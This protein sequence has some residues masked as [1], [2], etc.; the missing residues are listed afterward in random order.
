VTLVSLGLPVYNGER[1]LETALKALL[2][3][4][5]EDIELV[6]SDN[7][8]TDGTEEL[9]RSFAS[10]DSRIVYYRQE[11]N[12]GAAWNHNFVV[13]ASHGEYFRWCSYDDIVAPELVADCLEV[14]ESDPRAVLSFPGTYVIDG[15]G[16]IAGEY[17]MDLPWVGES[18]QSRLSNLLLPDLPDSLINYCYP[19]YGVIRR[20]VLLQ[21]P[22]LGTYQS[23]DNILLVE[24]ALRGGWIQVPRRLF[25]SRRHEQSSIGTRTKRE[26]AR[27]FNPGA[28]LRTTPMVHTNLLMGYRQ[29]LHR[30]P[31]GKRERLACYGIVVRWVFRDRN[32]R[33]IFHEFRQPLRERLTRPK[34]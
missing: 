11:V 22:L 12:R 33:M 6:I 10:A 17:T 8:S 30:V 26:I 25:Y 7:A 32:G 2:A 27:W 3:Q 16:E 13:R 15:A 19:I 4:S 24:L 21:T 29:A 1:Y 5:H 9:C 34:R 20:D 23:A 31:L 28:E 14:L 18:P